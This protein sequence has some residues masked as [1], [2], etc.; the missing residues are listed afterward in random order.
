MEFSRKKFILL[1]S[2][3][4]ALG[5]ISFGIFM[6]KKVDKPS[7]YNHYIEADSYGMMEVCYKNGTYS[8]DSVVAVTFPEIKSI[9]NERLEIFD[10]S[11]IKENAHYN[12]NSMYI[13]P[14]NVDGHENEAVKKALS[15]K[16]VKK[17]KVYTE[18][19]N[20]YIQDI[21]E[22]TFPK[23]ETRGEI[24]GS[25]AEELGK[26][27]TMYGTLMEDYELVAINGKSVDELFGT[28]EMYINDIR[29]TGD[30]LPIRFP[31]GE[32]NLKVIPKSNESQKDDK[33]DYVDKLMIFS[34]KDKK[35]KVSE[36]I[37]RF[38]KKDIK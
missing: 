26:K 13:Y 27:A 31:K 25:L 24:L 17:I 30:I 3:I 19:G 8:R 22:I 21:G 28:Y 33:Y 16:T 7:F 20:E 10:K 14:A 36:Y 29:L 38:A 18:N 35:G 32:F 12:I 23:T 5:V 6:Y 11:P 9:A 37:Y 1:F 4:I 15:G 34:L 2:G